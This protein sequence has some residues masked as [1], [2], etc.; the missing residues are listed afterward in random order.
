MNDQDI[1]LIAEESKANPAFGRRISSA[2]RPPG[3]ER[4]V[5]LSARKAIVN[6]LNPAMYPETKGEWMVLRRKAMQVVAAMPG[7]IDQMV[8][9][10]PLSAKLEAVRA[11]SRGEKPTMVLSGM[12]ELGQFEILGSIIGSI[13]G[14]G[15]SIYGARVTSSAQRDIANIQANAAIQSA[16]AQVAIANAQAAISQAQAQQLTQ[17]ANIATAQSPAGFLTA[18][19]GGGVPLWAIPAGLATLGIGAAIF[20]SFRRKR[21]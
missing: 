13:A 20:F 9:K 5:A 12:G 10:M 19:V 16:Q 8:S 3:G 6:Q 11:I 1:A 4:L 17:A 15:S 21:R 18:N 14:A 2:M 7:I